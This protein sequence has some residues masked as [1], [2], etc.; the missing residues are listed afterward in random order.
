VAD[1]S[2]G[3]RAAIVVKEPKYSLGAAK[4]LGHF[5][6]PKTDSELLP[7]VWSKAVTVHTPNL[8]VAVMG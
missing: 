8:M 6:H 2:S 4:E 3:E 1:T 7:N 5:G